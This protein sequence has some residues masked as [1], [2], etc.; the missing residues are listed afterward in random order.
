[1]LAAGEPLDRAAAAL[2]SVHGRGGTGDGILSL[3]E[4]LIQPGFAFLAPQAA[5]KTWY[6]LSF[7]APVER[8]EPHPSGALHALAL[9]I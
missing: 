9:P 2:I 3:A 6:P 7:L 1:V 5:G 4:E 8:S